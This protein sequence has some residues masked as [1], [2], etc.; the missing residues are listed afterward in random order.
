MDHL[1][2]LTDTSIRHGHAC[3]KTLRGNACDPGAFSEAAV[4]AA[5]DNHIP[6]QAADRLLHPL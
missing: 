6:A 3:N 2:I 1:H 5:A 4:E